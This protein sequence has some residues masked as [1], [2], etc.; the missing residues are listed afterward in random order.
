MTIDLALVDTLIAQPR[1]IAVPVSKP[2][3]TLDSYLAAARR[4][5]NRVPDGA[6]WDGSDEMVYTAEEYEAR[7]RRNSLESTKA[8]EAELAPA[9]KRKT[10]APAPA[11]KSAAAPVSGGAPSGSR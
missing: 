8:A 4:V 9:P 2:D 3:V 11:K 10:A 1:G 6:N 7:R 5:E